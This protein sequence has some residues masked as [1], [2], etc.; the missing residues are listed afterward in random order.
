[1]AA[2][3]TAEGGGSLREAAEEAGLVY[4]DDSRPGLTRKRSGTGFRYLDARGAPVR[5]KAVLARIKALAIPPA[6]TDVW[7]CARRNGHIQATGRDA[8]GRK[9]YRYHP[10]FRQAREADKFSRIMAFAGA[11]PGIRQRVDADMKRP[12]LSRETVLATVVHLLETTLI[13]VGNDDYARTN[14]SYGLTTLR[15]PHVRI[16]GSALSF[17]FKGKSGK[18]WDVSLKD[19]R[20][21]RI[22]KACQDLPGQELFQYL[23]EDG[24]QRDV[25]S[26]DVN[27]YLR[28]IT[29]EDFTAKDFRTWA[30]T[31]LA[32]LALREF[33][34]FDTDAAAKRNVRAAIESVAGRLGNTPT[35]C[36]KCYIHP[37]ILDCY[38]EGGLLLHV[39]EVVE[40]ELSED[41]PSLRSEEAAVLA[42]L[43][44]RLAAS[45]GE[46]RDGKRVK[47][48][49]KN[50]S[51][52]G[53]TGQRKAS[54]AKAERPSRAGTD[55]RAG[56]A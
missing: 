33:E 14:K 37:Q 16:E 2:V 12:G 6:Y 51:S 39:K 23:D 31:V 28:A 3:E 53:R 27:A 11:L 52:P 49:A 43:H 34:S 18:T 8:K 21:A 35:I 26:S 47:P 9:Q 41:L 4:V 38:M 15:D 7:I 36:R 32:A 17:R 13:R 56:A 19:R 45:E 54:A 20:V 50:R 29:G 10:D 48:A 22:V 24:T 40:S 30:G 1:M 42:L 5:D 44:A 55:T 46:A 25:T